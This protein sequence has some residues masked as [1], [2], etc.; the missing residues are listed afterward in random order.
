MRLGYV[1]LGWAAHAFHLPAVRRVPG[2]VVVGGCDSSA[3]RRA[4]WERKTGTPSFQ[5]L[6]T[7]LERADP[8]VVVVATPPDSHAELCLEA[9]AAG[10][11]VFCEKPFVSN[12]A[13]ASRVIAAAASADRAVAVNHEFR[14]KPI[15]RAVR[16]AIGTEGVGELV[17]CQVWQLMN[18]APWDEHVPWRAAMRDRALFEG[19]VHLVD[20]LMTMFD[21]V[22]EAVF[23]RRS[24]GRRRDQAADAINLVTLDF[25][26]GLLGQITI[27]RLCQAATRYVDVRADCEHASLR[28]SE[29]GRAVLQV[30]M[31]RAERSGARLDLGLGG[32][33]WSERGVR[34]KTL[35]RSPRDPAVFATAALL[36]GVLEAMRAGREPPSSARQARDVMAVI[37]AAYQ[38]AESGE[39]IELDWD[40][41]RAP[42]AAT[43][44]S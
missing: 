4:E 7:M 38:S 37:E 40:S 33:A 34:R 44:S 17:F 39:R 3:E 6:A 36:A 29:G 13:E 23:A 20:L 1:G 28:A 30:G 35:G 43:S 19:G 21:G 12:V 15:F 5:T 9:L 26:G 32:L 11:H 31:K 27:D 24:S 25:P 22:P 10:R 2:A 8:E 41:I 42:T 16:E 18:L 14:E